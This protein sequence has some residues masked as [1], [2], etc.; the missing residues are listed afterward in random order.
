MSS[1]NLAKK[2]QPAKKAW[3]SFTNTLQSRLSKLRISKAIRKISCIAASCSIRPLIPR[4][5]GNLPRNQRHYRG[6]HLHHYHNHHRHQFQSNFA[7]IYVGQ[8]FLEPAL[9][10]TKHMDP[11]GE[12][13]KAKG[14]AASS[15]ATNKA[16]AEA[17]TMNIQDHKQKQKQV[18]FPTPAVEI[19][20]EKGLPRKS[21][22]KAGE[23]S[24]R[25]V[26]DA[27]KAAVSS[28]PHLQCV[29]E[30][31]EEFISKF[32]QDMKLEREQSIVE[33]QEMLA[34]GA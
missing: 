21:K 25:T 34:R 9:M 26:E 28:L 19:I 33:F 31:A 30:R 15:S 6:S 10:N 4:K 8:L 17:T 18:H 32:R 2:L 3:R 24:T 7:A 29:D 1:L 27:W 16:K 20:D 12:A 5:L 13:S 14:T 22:P 11:L 23:T